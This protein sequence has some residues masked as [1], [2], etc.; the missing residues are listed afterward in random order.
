MA[1][2]VELVHVVKVV[3]GERR[4]PRVEPVER[5]VDLPAQAVLLVMALG[6]TVAVRSWERPSGHD[7]SAA[8]APDWLRPVVPKRADSGMSS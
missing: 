8:E 3:G 4:M 1:A 6:R 5:F 7:R 2:G